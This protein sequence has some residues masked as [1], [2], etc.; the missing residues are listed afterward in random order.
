MP[1][2]PNSRQE[3]FVRFVAAGLSAT[4]A[5]RK[6]GYN[7]KSDDVAGAAAARLLTDVRVRNRLDELKPAVDEQRAEAL[8]L[9]VA[10]I[11]T[12]D[13]RSKVGRVTA[14]ENR[15]R[16]LLQVIAERA[17]APDA[18]NVPGGTT[19]YVVTGLKAVGT[20]TIKTNH[21]DLGLLKELREI[22]DQIAVELGHRM[23]RKQQVPMTLDELKSLPVFEQF[24]EAAAKEA[25]KLGLTGDEPSPDRGPN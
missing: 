10:G 15:R 11:L 12:E 2:L 14:L 23:D 7:V 13:V 24:L 22:E 6:A 5:Y 19:G 9:A 3:A 20:T 17:K 1:E 4:S 16:G 18:Q 21:V 25:E 8:E